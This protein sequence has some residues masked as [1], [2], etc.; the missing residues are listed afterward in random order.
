VP[1][2]IAAMH[3]QPITVAET[4]LFVRQAAD[5]WNDEERTGFINFIA[6]NP[7]AGDLIP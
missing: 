4:S 7:Q 6:A 1:Y 5:I 3:K 2:I